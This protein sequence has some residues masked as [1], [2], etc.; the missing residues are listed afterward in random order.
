MKKF[1]F[2]FAA[3]VATSVAMSFTSC[4]GKD[5]K[6]GDKEKTE[7][8]EGKEC[9]KDE[10]CTANEECCK[11]K[12]ECCKENKECCKEAEANADTAAEPATEDAADVPEA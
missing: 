2:V 4:K 6:E 1:A 10:C 11:E 7:C 5:A 9:S 12:E 8:A 3:V